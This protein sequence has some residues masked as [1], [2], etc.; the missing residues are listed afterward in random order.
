MEQ[1]WMVV[2]KNRTPIIV[3]MYRRENAQMEVDEL[4]KTGLTEFAPYRVVE[5]TVAMDPEV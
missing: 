5:D 1:R 4:N 3:G 2:D